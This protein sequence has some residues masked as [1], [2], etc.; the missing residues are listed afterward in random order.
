[1]KNPSFSFKKSLTNINMG[2]KSSVSEKYLQNNVN[3]LKK[4]FNYFFIFSIT[5]VIYLLITSLLLQNAAD[6]L[7]KDLWR[8]VFML[9]ILLMLLIFAANQRKILQNSRSKLII[10]V[11]FLVLN[12]LNSAIFLEISPETHDFSLPKDFHYFW[13]GYRLCAISIFT[14]LFTKCLFVSISSLFLEILLINLKFNAVSAEETYK[15]AILSIIFLLMYSFFFVISEKKLYDDLENRVYQQ[16]DKKLFK[17]LLDCLPEAL[18]ILNKENK[19][20]YSNFN[21]KNF[22]NNYSKNLRGNLKNDCFIEDFFK[23]FHLCLLEKLEKQENFSEN[24][25]GSPLIFQE[26]SQNDHSV[27]KILIIFL[28]DFARKLS[29][30]V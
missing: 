3:F 26:N 18:I 6:F 13:M 1:M 30:N 10:R 16:E 11:Y 8:F 24:L 15:A 9:I 29:K 27:R 28:N 20:F 4:G 21:A 2:L 19:V 23:S 17:K 7:R 22:I 14:K 5:N 25:Q 12:L